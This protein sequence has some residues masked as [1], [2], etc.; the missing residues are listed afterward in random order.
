[1]AWAVSAA[2]AMNGS[3]LMSFGSYVALLKLKASTGGNY[4]VEAE[5]DAHCEAN[6]ARFKRPRVIKFVDALPRNATGKIHKPTLRKNF[7]S[8]DA[9]GTDKA[10]VT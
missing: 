1:M 2:Y 8:P 7:I 4:M 3:F 9:I 6:L 10:V 5:I